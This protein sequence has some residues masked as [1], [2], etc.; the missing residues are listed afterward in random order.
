MVELDFAILDV[1][2]EPLAMSPQFVFRL[3]VANRTPDVAIQSV[4][5]KQC[6][7][8]LPTAVWRDMMER[9]YPRSVWLRL[10]REVFDSP[11]RYK[12][13]RGFPSFAQVLRSLVE[14]E[15]ASLPS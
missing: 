10:N 3:R 1:E 11:Y 9:H 7:F 4:M 2:L 15:L 13:Q 8:R 12:R 14:G 6:R 5:L